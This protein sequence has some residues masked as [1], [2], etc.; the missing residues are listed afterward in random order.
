MQERERILDLVKKGVLST[1]EALILLEN[2]ATEKD[3]KLI[4]LEETQ[5]KYHK[6]LE[7]D[8]VEDDS[9]DSTAVDD[10]IL[11]EILEQIVAEESKKSVEYDNLSLNL[12]DIRQDIRDTKEQITVLNTMEDLDTLTETKRAERDQLEKELAYLEQTELLLDE[13]REQLSDELKHLKKEKRDAEQNEFTSKFDIPEDW[14]EQAGDAINQ[15]TDKMGEAGNQFSKFIKKTIDVVTTTVN[16]NVDWK[17]V[18]IKV[19]GVASHQFK[20][21]FFY[22]NINISIIDIKVANGKVDIKSWNQN[23]IKIEANIKFYGKLNHATPLEAFI[24]R[25]EISLE[26][27]TLSLQVP[28]KRLSCEFTIY[29]P[30]HTYDFVSVKMLNGDVEIKELLVGDM[31]LK[32]TNGE[33]T[34]KDVIGT[35][36]EIQGV[37][38]SMDLIDCKLVDFIGQ[39]VNGNIITKSMIESIQASLVNGDIKLTTFND[40]SKVNATTINGDLKVSVP[41]AYGIDGV[42]QTNFGSIKNRLANIEVL[43]E[44]TDKLNQYQEFRRNQ[45]EIVTL[46]LNTKTGSIYLKDNE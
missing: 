43:R 45:E 42:C 29:L 40:I 26:N 38:G 28:N 46:S 6:E 19:P 44:K 7:K 17:D 13:E 16:D 5:I 36:L 34:V 2:I 32:T 41:S 15:M 31:F 27:D 11:E 37:N 24:E 10:S 14:K 20:H 3:E 30:K 35:M 33:V 8:Q 22:P 21:E 25:S 18:N 1:E 9:F 23:D 4:N 12:Q 39:T